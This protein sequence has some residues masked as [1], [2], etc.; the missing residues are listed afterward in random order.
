[1]VTRLF[2][3]LFAACVAIP[4]QSQSQEVPTPT[5]QSPD[6]QQIRTNAALEA[7]A[8]QLSAI[9]EQTARIEEERARRESNPWVSVP[10]W[11]ALLLTG[12]A[13]V[14]AFMTLAKLERQIKAAQDAADAATESAGA[15]TV[16]ASMAKSGVTIDADSLSTNREIERAY[17]SFGHS[18]VVVGYES[19]GRGGQDDSKPTSLSVKI[20]IR[21][22]GRT[23]GDFIGGY[24]GFN[25]G[26]KPAV[27]DLSRGIN[28][29][30]PVFLLP[31][32]DTWF[33]WEINEPPETWREV[34]LGDTLLWLEGEADY[35]DRF[36]QLH[37]AGYGRWFDPNQRLFVF[38]PETG[39]WNYDRLMHPDKVIHYD[40]K[41]GQAYSQ[42]HQ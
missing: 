25:L 31:N 12:G 15:A 29:L 1:M 36:G 26:P 2:V 27:P 6:D 9:R 41:D 21:N 34:F 18:D 38:R 4:A 32:K 13:V 42:R 33:I 28:T 20:H 7:I 8:S 39:P 10:T 3:L 40:I 19:D 30:A 14:A 5:N 23:P 24:F 11:L 17:I 37:T 35:I 22:D 16:A